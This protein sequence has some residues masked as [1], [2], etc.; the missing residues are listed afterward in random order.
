MREFEH[1]KELDTDKPRRCVVCGSLTKTVFNIQLMAIPVCETCANTIT[2]QQVQ[3][4][5]TKRGNI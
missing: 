4:L 3:H 1:P 2:L 5:V